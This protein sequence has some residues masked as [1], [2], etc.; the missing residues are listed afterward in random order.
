MHF[1]T[2]IPASEHP[3]EARQWRV[4]GIPQVAL[5]AYSHTLRGETGQRNGIRGD[6]YFGID[7]G[8]AKRFHTVPTTRQKTPTSK[9]DLDFRSSAI[10]DR[11][12]SGRGAALDSCNRAR[13]SAR[14]C[15]SA[16]FFRSS[17]S[18]R[19]GSSGAQKGWPHP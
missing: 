16:N 15:S 6:G 19:C 9:P 18:I 3:S 17:S 11:E 1:L 5:N 8:I 2:W 12:A 13:T 14:Y 7:L 4:L 10:G